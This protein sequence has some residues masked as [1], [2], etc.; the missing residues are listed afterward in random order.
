[1]SV[2][3]NLISEMIPGILMAV[4][5]LAGVASGEA[6]HPQPVVQEAAVDMTK[7]KV[8]LREVAGDLAIQVIS[9][10]GSVLSSQAENAPLCGDDDCSGSR[11]GLSRS[12]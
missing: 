5:V 7:V 9:G 3:K 10:A 6:S 1:M 12:F 8:Q 11:D 2:K 4:L